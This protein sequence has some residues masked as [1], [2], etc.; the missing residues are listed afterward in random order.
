MF[1][2][3]PAFL[4]ATL[5]ATSAA[6]C[7]TT[8]T[9]TCTRAELQDS[10]AHHFPV[11]R[12]AFM[13][14]VTLANPTVILRPGDNR[15]GVQLDAE[16]RSPL[17]SPLHGRI[18]ALGEPFYDREKKAFFIRKP[19]VER[20]DF[21]GFDSSRHATIR[22]AVAAVAERALDDIPVYRLEGRNATEKTA[23]WLLKEVHVGDEKLHLTLGPP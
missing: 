10:V 8:Y 14:A 12:E 2:A 13:V 7:S 21:Q 6:A 1:T 4:L 5:A 20:L 22:Q 23:E 15:I 18:A 11:T 3:R 16:V 17:G 19:A 9:I